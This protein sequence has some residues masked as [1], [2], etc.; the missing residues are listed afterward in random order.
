LRIIAVKY[1][2]SLSEVQGTSLITVRSFDAYSRE[3]IFYLFGAIFSSLITWANAGTD[4]ESL[5]QLVCNKR[6]GYI[7]VK[8]MRGKKK[9]HLCEWHTCCQFR[10]MPVISYGTFF[11]TLP[12]LYLIIFVRK[13]I[14]YCIVFFSS[15]PLSSPCV[16]DEKPIVFILYLYICISFRRLSIG[17]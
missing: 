1:P 12:T 11:I 8:K 16:D 4:N 3:C 7:Y 6:V 5:L 13:F 10:P 15:W 2:S 14:I 17:S 9:R